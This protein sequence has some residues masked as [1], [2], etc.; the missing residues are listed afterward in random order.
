MAMRKPCACSKI[1]SH[2]DNSKPAH[3]IP[4]TA[5]SSQRKQERPDT[6]DSISVAHIRDC[7]RA[8]NAIITPMYTA[9]LLTKFGSGTDTETIFP[10]GTTVP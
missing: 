7:R 10:D 8:T 5:R 1:Q 9:T 2:C 3:S 6:G 4:T